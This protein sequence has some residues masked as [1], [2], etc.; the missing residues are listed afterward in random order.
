MKST[1]GREIFVMQAEATVSADRVPQ[2]A[3]HVRRRVVRLITICVIGLL[4]LAWLA[5]GSGV[6]TWVI[7]LA[8]PA[9]KASADDCGHPAGGF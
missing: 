7:R 9:Y 1:S 6:K 2:V 5:K 8:Y 4:L 3:R